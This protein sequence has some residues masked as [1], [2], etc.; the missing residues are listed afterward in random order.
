MKYTTV[1]FVGGFYADENRP[2]S[3][4][5]C[6]NY[7]PTSA[8]VPN[9]RTPQRL[10]TAPG[11][12]PYVY[13]GTNPIR[14]MYNAEGRLFVLAGNNLY[15]VSNA[16]VA[17]LL[18]TVPGVGR[19]SFAHNQI[20]NGVQVL[21]NN[22]SSGYVY[23]S[24]AGTFTRITDAGYPGGT[25]AVFIDGYIIQIEPARRYAF[26]S[27]A[28][29]ATSY[30]TLDQFTSEVSPDLLVGLAVVNNELVL[31]SQ[32]T[33]EFFEDTGA[34]SEPFRTK[35]ITM[36]RGCG[37]QFTIVNLDNTLYW[38]GNDGIFYMLNGYQ[39]MRISTFPIE[40][41]IANLDWSQAFAFTYESK[42]HKIVYWTF[43]DGHT[44]G[45]DVASRLWHR[46]ESYGLNRWRV[47]A[48]VNWNGEWLAGDFQN[49]V[50]WTVDWDYMLEG[51]NPYICQRTTGVLSD[52]QNL[53]LVPRLEVVMETGQPQTIPIDPFTG[54]VS[55]TGNLP[56]GTQGDVVSIQYQASGGIAPFTFT[57]LSGAIPAGL[58][59]SSSGLLSGTYSGSGV[60][61][62]VVKVTDAVGSTATLADGNTVTSALIY[63]WSLTSP[64]SNQAENCVWIDGNIIAVAHDNNKVS[65]SLDR[66]VTWSNT[67]PLSVS[68]SI[69]GIVKYRGDWWIFG[70]NGGT[71]YSAK[72]I[73]DNLS[74]FGSQT[75]LA[76]QIGQATIGQNCAWSDGT[77]MYVSERTGT[78]YKLHRYDGTTWI[79]Y[80]TG[81][82]A[83]DTATCIGTWCVSN[84]KFVLGTTDGYI[85]QGSSL[86]AMSIV[87]TSSSTS[88]PIVGLAKVGSKI[89]AGTG[90]G[91]ILSSTNDGATWG[92][93]YS[94]S[95]GTAGGRY[96]LS[97]G[98]MFMS[99]YGSTVYTS[100]DGTNGSW[101]QRFTTL[102]ASYRGLGYA[103]RTLAF[104]P[105]FGTY[106]FLGS[107]T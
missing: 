14:G 28:A 92:G 86:S 107:S 76:Y 85:L 41:A 80:S 93:S 60:Y 77:Y 72:T 20:S 56:N 88:A 3:V 91:L 54:M 43:P 52:N 48:M 18:G 38:L 82:A 99:S 13:F 1:P 45:Y 49:G 84:G 102:S 87:Y 12:K 4:Q 32:T 98:V 37:G 10:I 47:N 15:L 81:V 23:D 30:N 75:T 34:T 42:G 59:L 6:L 22:G 96:V 83:R 8:E 33:T 21:V 53:V 58:T 57:V 55:I 69:N 51:L 101:V 5:D 25:G 27:A 62:W 89:I 67:S 2:F 24:V 97:N 63:N 36:T 71:C 73:G 103:S 105:T 100:T 78:T 66:G 74:S 106:G 9:T 68:A 19:V 17:T 104:Y 26:N 95:G 40:Q 16:G 35:R 64:L 50:T 7:L 31:F 65:Y 11:L 90:D 39:P 46:R 61:S 44:W 94:A 79:T 29:D 70:N